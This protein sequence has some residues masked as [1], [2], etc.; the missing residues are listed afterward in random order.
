MLILI[1][2]KFKM[3]CSKIKFNMIRVA[4]ECNFGL[5]KESFT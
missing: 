3:D 2:I 1:S 4:K 5:A